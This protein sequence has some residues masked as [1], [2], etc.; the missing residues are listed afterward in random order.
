MVCGATPKSVDPQPRSWAG[1]W[2]VNYAKDLGDKSGGADVIWKKGA[3]NEFELIKST[4]PFGN[5]EVYQCGK[6]ATVPPIWKHCLFFRVGTHALQLPNSKDSPLPVA[7]WDADTADNL[8]RSANAIKPIADLVLGGLPQADT[9][10]LIGSIDVAGNI[11][12]LV[13]YRLVDGIADGP[14]RK[15][16]L[17][18]DLID[19]TSSSGGAFENGWGSGG[20]K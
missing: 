11:E 19:P 2:V 13:L 7:K 20:K 9:E 4:L 14:T 8:A 16:L 12:Y 1:R 10:R 18:I 15:D 5:L 3:D 17:I 6:D